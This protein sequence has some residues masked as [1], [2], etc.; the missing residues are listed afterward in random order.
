MIGRMRIESLSGPVS[1]QEQ[2][3]EFY[4]DALGYELLVDGVW[5]EG[6]RWSEGLAFELLEGRSS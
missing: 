4:V 5:R 2:A 3:K 1:G 6:M